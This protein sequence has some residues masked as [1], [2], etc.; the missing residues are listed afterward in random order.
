MMQID[1]LRAGQ[2]GYICCNVKDIRKFRVGDTLF[3]QG[4]SKL[5]QPFEG[6]MGA[7]PMVFAGIYP[8]NMEESEQ[9]DIAVQRY[10]LT[11]PAVEAKR[12]RSDV[13]GAGFRCGF[14]G[15]LH[16]DV[17]KQRLLQ[18][19]KM[20]VLVT[21]PTVPYVVTD[22]AGVQKVV[23]NA[24]DFPSPPQPTQEPIVLARLV[25]PEDLSADVQKLC[26]ERRGEVK[27]IES[28]D[29]K[30]VLLVVELPFAEVLIDFFDRLQSISHGYASFDYEPQGYRAAEIVKVTTRLNNDPCEAL[31]FL[32]IKS[33]STKYAKSFVQKLEKLIPSQQF[34]ISIQALIGGKVVAKTVIKALRRDIIAQKILAHGHSGDPLRKKKLLDKQ[35]EGKK[36]LREISNVQVPSEAF[37]EMMKL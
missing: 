17:F 19:Y 20:A 8:E 2:V 13:L 6:F 34:D 33:S 23:E 32:C 7:K 36:R 35:K 15:L 10:L 3:A 16:L 25:V 28:F 14:L 4:C 22:A 29:G 37:V 21:S 9:L 5:S 11:D 18:E 27:S 26:Y 30:R 12:E 1:A 24:Q 31:S